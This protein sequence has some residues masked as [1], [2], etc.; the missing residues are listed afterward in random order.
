M[1]TVPKHD[2]LNFGTCIFPLKHY[3]FWCIY[4]QFH[5][6]VV[7][8]TVFDEEM[9][10]RLQIWAMPL[11]NQS[12]SSIPNIT[13]SLTISKVVETLKNHPMF[14]PLSNRT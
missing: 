14:L 8:E 5:R 7:L 4:V 10:L 9:N 12:F 6:G 3:L 2:G 1:D 13:K 11:V